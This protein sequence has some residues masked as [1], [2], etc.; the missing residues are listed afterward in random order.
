MLWLALLRRPV[1]AMD[2]KEPKGLHSTLPW[3]LVKVAEEGA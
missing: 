2:T 1:G 3:T